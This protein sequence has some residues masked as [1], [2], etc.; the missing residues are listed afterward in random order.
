MDNRYIKVNP[1]TSAVTLSP[2]LARELNITRGESG[3]AAVTLFWNKE[4]GLYGLTRLSA[5]AQ[6]VMFSNVV[7]YNP[8][9]K[10]FGFIMGGLHD[11]LTVAGML[12]T[13]G[14]DDMAE[15]TIPVRRLG[16]LGLR[17]HYLMLEGKP[18][19]PLTMLQR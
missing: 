2:R 14:I 9:T 18:V 10:R 17:F 11:Q 5:F 12:D 1:V 19:K 4:K 13:Y 6:H 15:R 8:V 7:S 3:T 16:P